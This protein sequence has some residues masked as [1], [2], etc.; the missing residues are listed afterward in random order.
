MSNI[1]AQLPLLLLELLPLHKKKNEF[2]YLFIFLSNGYGDPK[3]NYTDECKTVDHNER[4]S[5]EKMPPSIIR[6][7]I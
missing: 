3:T 6:P 2:I 1:G 7:Q 5:G 4:S